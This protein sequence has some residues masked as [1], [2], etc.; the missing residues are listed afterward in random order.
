MPSRPTAS[1]AAA[2]SPRGA[3]L[4]TGRQV[5]LR[6]HRGAG[7]TP[8]AVNTLEHQA[9]LSLRLTPRDRWLIRM[10]HEHQVLT[11]AQITQT[12]FPSARSATTRLL[13]LYRWRVLDRF[14][15]FRT[16]GT[17]PMHYVLDI[18]GAGIL[19]AE[20]GLDVKALGYRH[21]RAIGIAHSLHLA[22]TVG[23]NAFFCAL[24]ATTR[25]PGPP[26]DCP[27]GPGGGALTALWSEARCQRL[28]GDL[29]RPDGYAR[30]REAHNGG[31]REVEFFLE[32]DTGS[33]NLTQLI[34]KLAGYHALAA[35]TGIR[36]PLLIWLPTTRRETN[37]R[38]ALAA[39]LASLD[40]PGLV[41]VATSAADLTPH[42]MTHRFPTVQAEDAVVGG[43][44]G[45][46]WLPLGPSPHGSGTHGR[47]RLA[48]LAELWPGSLAHR[49]PAS[50][51][52]NEAPGVH[53]VGGDGRPPA[54]DPM[55]PAPPRV[56]EQASRSTARLSANLQH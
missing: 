30:W 14:Q 46:R 31:I 12:A 53:Q 32:Y 15:P 23:V 40:R 11:S 1:S 55:P 42:M 49:P 44:A 56:L 17:A 8:R 9:R 38:Q 19:A 47:V 48:A 7:R 39:A 26:G 6:S 16:V 34:R 4:S 2:S 33:E 25:H 18:A 51:G 52:S 28:F 10:L 54:P 35:A 29:V 43:P 37:A 50:P 20:D 22:H 24:I 13:E 3:V 45:A 5:A 36:T 27:Y 21:E 41:P